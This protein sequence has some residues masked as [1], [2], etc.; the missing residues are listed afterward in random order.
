[1]LLGASQALSLFLQGEAT[2]EID[3]I[4]RYHIPIT[5]AVAEIDVKSFEYELNISRL[6]ESEDRK[7]GELEA[8]R[9]R[10]DEKLCLKSSMPGGTRP[11]A[12]R[13]SKIRIGSLLPTTVSRS[14]SLVSTLSR[15]SRI[16]ASEAMMAVP[17]TLLTPSSRDA[18]L[19]ASR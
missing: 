7:P 11:L 8:A 12:A 18:G 5:A 4:S 3:A 14:N 13:I 17:K 16:V 19:T 9:K 10:Q 1:M 2:E 15:E 6:L